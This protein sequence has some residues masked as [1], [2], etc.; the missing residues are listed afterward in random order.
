MYANGYQAQWASSSYKV[1][2]LQILSEKQRA[3]LPRVD[4]NTLGI[5]N[6]S[7]LSVLYN[8]KR[9]MPFVTAYNI[10]GD[11]QNA[12]RATFRSDPRVVESLQLNDDFYDL[13]PKSDKDFEIGHMAAHDE[14]AWGNEAQLQA[15]RTFFFTNSCPQVKRLNAGLWRGLEQYFIREA[16]QLKNKKAHFFTG[17]VLSPHDPKYI[18]D[19]SVQ[20]PLFFYKVVVFEFEARLCCTAFMMSQAKRVRELKLIEEKATEKFRPLDKEMPFMDYNYGEVFQ[21]D[22]SLVEKATNLTF[23]WPGVQA[24]KV[25]GGMEKLEAIGDVG[26]SSD[27]K[28]VIE[29]KELERLRKPAV[30]NFRWS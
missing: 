30:K 24:V 7:Y 17:P 12:D 14:M 26:S 27:L 5:L 23:S 15:Y 9:R 3:L 6:Y 11:N 10:T 28:K 21:V 8:S 18:D 13:I 25:P 22:V 19:P 29:T 4:G 20:I 16:K 2:L 1:E